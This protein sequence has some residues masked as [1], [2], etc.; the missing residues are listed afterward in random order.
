MKQYLEASTAAYSF[1][2]A[3]ALQQPGLSIYFERLQT[4]TEVAPLTQRHSAQI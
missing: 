4:K 3:V 1:G 2:R